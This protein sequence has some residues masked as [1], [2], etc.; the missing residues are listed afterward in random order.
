LKENKI[1]GYLWHY[2]IIQRQ[3][4]VLDSFNKKIRYICFDLS[5]KIIVLYSGKIGQELIK[6]YWQIYW[7]HNSLPPLSIATKSM[8]NLVVKAQI[9]WHVFYICLAT[10]FIS[11]NT[12]IFV[13]P[14]CTQHNTPIN[15]N[16]LL[17]SRNFLSVH[18][19]I[20]ACPVVNRV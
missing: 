5:E 3:L 13:Q 18:F 1:K 14:A 4:A 9:K 8:N 12:C 15:T 11:M 16:T 7:Q 19:T 17:Y 20:L 6:L 10:T 2:I